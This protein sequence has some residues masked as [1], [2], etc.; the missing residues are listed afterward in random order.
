MC[1][2]ASVFMGTIILRVKTYKFVKYSLPQTLV[3]AAKFR[4]LESSQWHAESEMKD[5]LGK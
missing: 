2:Y 1:I 4:L 3:L 5:Y